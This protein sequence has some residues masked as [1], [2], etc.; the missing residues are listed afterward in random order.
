MIGLAENSRRPSS[1][2]VPSSHLIISRIILLGLVSLMG[3]GVL[4]L[5]T[6]VILRIYC[7]GSL[8][9]I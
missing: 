8:V 2:V 1:C 9:V 4:P 3:I 5:S 6:P 7:R